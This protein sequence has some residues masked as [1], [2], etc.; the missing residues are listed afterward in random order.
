[1][2][3]RMCRP[4]S[5]LGELLDRSRNSVLAL[6]AHDV[7]WN[8]VAQRNGDDVVHAPQPANRPAYLGSGLTRDLPA[9]GG[10]AA[11]Q[12]PPVRVEDA[13]QNV[14]TPVRARR[15]LGSLSQFGAG[16]P[17][18]RRRLEPRCPAKRRRCCPRPSAG[19][20]SRVP[21]LWPDARPAGDRRP[22]RL[23]DTSSPGRR[24]PPE[25]AD[26]SPSSAS[27]WIALAIRCWPSQRTTSAGTSLPSETAT[28]L[29][30]PLSRRTVPR[31]SALA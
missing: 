21:R 6:P 27:S 5:E 29:S 2:P 18:A 9:I 23:P 20:P 15:A 17:S 28:M 7:G 1:M 11:Y 19:E 14:Q 12:I 13:R 24:C 30:T 26:P 31:T 8:L 22:S 16:P 10:R 25:C 3:A 4:Q